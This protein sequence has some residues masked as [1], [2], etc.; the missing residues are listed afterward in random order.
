MAILSN[1]VY[2]AT[3]EGFQN[4]LEEG[5]VDENAIV[6]IEDVF[7]MWTHGKYFQFESVA[8]SSST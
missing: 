6:F 5:T 2:A 3:L 1:V 8:S 7:Q 4:A